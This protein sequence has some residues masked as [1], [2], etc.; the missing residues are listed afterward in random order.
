MA[1]N[2]DEARYQREI[3]GRADTIR[4]G[5]SIILKMTSPGLNAPR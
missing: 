2:K 1:K 3:P 4:W 5:W